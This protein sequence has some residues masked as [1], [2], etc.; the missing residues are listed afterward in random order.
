[1]REICHRVGIAAPQRRAYEEFAPKT[2]LEGRQSMNA[3]TMGKLAKIRVQSL[4]DSADEDRQAR[5]APSQ[6]P[7]PRLKRH[8]HWHKTITKFPSR[9]MSK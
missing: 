4:V 8:F 7:T 5:P 2:R 6:R 1:V 3:F 9:A